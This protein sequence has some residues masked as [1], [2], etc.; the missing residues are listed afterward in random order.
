MFS[1]FLG[2]AFSIRLRSPLVQVLVNI[3][4]FNWKINWC[5]RIRTLLH[6]QIVGICRNILCNIL[7]QKYQTK[8]FWYTI[9]FRAHNTGSIIYPR[10]NHRSSF[11]CGIQHGP[12]LVLSI[13]DP[14]S[15]PLG[16]HILCPD[17]LRE[18]QRRIFQ[19]IS[20]VVLCGELLT[21]LI[22]KA[23]HKQVVIKIRPIGRIDTKAT[24][25]NT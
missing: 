25:Y 18:L 15:I 8:I 5:A 4:V 9:G 2:S 3:N 1:N 19:F 24:Q 6:T 22:S 23:N 21:A 11:V 10:H 14:R 7:L 20:A 17:E 13:Y 16:K 12:W